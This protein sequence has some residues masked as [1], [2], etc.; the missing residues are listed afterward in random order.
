MTRRLPTRVPETGPLPQMR[1]QAKT[2][3]QIIELLRASELRESASVRIERTAN[4]T[5]VHS[6]GGT[7]AGT[8]DD[9]WYG[10]IPFS[11]V[12]WNITCAAYS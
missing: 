4:G 11:L 1:D 5:I 8:I 12:I 6:K 3:N 7:S 2:I 9:T 10:F